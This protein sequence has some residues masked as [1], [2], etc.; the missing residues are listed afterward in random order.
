MIS[1]KKNVFVSVITGEGNYIVT[2]KNWDSFIY[3][4]NSSYK[5]LGND[6]YTNA[7]LTINGSGPQY[8]GV[9]F[10]EKFGDYLNLFFAPVGSTNFEPLEVKTANGELIVEPKNCPQ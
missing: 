10:L 6:A 7:Y 4:Y 9:R 2:V 3:E 1:T 5:V 8:A